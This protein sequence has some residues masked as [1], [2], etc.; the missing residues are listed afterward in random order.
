MA[1]VE[2][3]TGLPPYHELD[4]A[5]RLIWALNSSLLQLHDNLYKNSSSNIASN[6]QRFTDLGAGTFRDWQTQTVCLWVSF[7]R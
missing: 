7:G 2:H 4:I 3:S 6:R 1:W 5:S